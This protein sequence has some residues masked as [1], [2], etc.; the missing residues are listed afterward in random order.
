[1]FRLADRHNATNFV[2]RS[3]GPKLH[4]WVVCCLVSCPI[5]RNVGHARVAIT[6]S[7]EAPTVTSR[8]QNMHVRALISRCLLGVPNFVPIFGEILSAEWHLE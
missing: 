3:T 7:D 6:G 5:C 4:V 8:T 1:M 2:V